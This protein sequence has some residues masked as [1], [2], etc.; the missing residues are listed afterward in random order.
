METANELFLAS[1]EGDYDDES[2]WNAVRSLRQRSTEEVF[3]LAVAYCRS[4][5]PKRRARAL[6]GLAQLGAG[7][8]LSERPHFSESVAIALAH[9]HDEDPLVVY[10]AVWALAHLN[11]SRAV[12]ALIEMRKHPDPDIRHAVACGMANSD[13]PEAISTLIE[14]M[15]DENDE[16][17]NWSTFQPAHSYVEDGPERPGSLTSSE[18]R[19]AFRRRLNDSFAE[20]REEA[21]W[22]LALRKN[23]MGL[24]LLLERL[25]CE[26]HS[27][28]DAMTAAEI[29][30]LGY[31][32]PVEELRI[33]LR[34]L[35]NAL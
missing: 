9:L 34:C 18:I 15:E 29:F 1:F 35:L 30:D 25:D 20:V 10:S 12:A 32:T 23:P 19:D 4:D 31:D 14:L 24:K 27:P 28:G 17:R 2:A 5:S 3:Q 21:I 8:Q 11:D 6:D 33:G 7:K 13:R 22:G 16:V 26:Q